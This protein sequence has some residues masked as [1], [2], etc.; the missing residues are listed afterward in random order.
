MS[1]SQSPN[2]VP[3]YDRLGGM[4]GPDNASIGD[5]S[6]SN[7]RY[8]ALTGFDITEQ[9]IGLPPAPWGAALQASSG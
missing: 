6:E 5:A 3:P 7:L 4:I 9:K 1:A 8:H 2:F